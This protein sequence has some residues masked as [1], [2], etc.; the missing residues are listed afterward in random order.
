MY[1]SNRSEEI[2]QDLFR[3][4]SSLRDNDSTIEHEVRRILPK[5]HELRQETAKAFHLL[6]HLAKHQRSNRAHL[7]VSAFLEWRQVIA[8]IVGP[9]ST[10]DDWLDICRLHKYHAFQWSLQESTA[11]ALQTVTM[12]DETDLDSRLHGLA[13]TLEMNP[14]I[15]ENWIALVRGLGP[16]G[17]IVGVN[18]QRKCREAKCVACEKIVDGLNVD[19]SSLKDRKEAGCWWGNDRKDWWYENLLQLDTGTEH[20]VHFIDNFEGDCSALEAICIAL[21]DTLYCLESLGWERSSVSCSL[22]D[23]ERSVDWLEDLIHNPLSSMDDKQ[24]PDELRRQTVDRLLPRTF[25]ERIETP[26]HASTESLES[27]EL[28]GSDADSLEIQCAKALILCHLYSAAHPDIENFV[29]RL[30]AESW[31]DGELYTD[32][33][34]F[35]CLRW[36][37]LVGLDV[38]KIVG[39]VMTVLHE[40]P[41]AAVKCSRD[42][43]RIRGS[44]KLC[45]ECFYLAK[46]EHPNRNT[47][48]LRKLCSET[49]LGCPKCQVFLCARH[50]LSFEHKPEKYN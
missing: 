19:H 35:S 3:S 12:L 1:P 32:G 28:T 33:D 9:H 29:L 17:C 7:A 5:F 48:W 45:Q 20:V 21:E 25:A 39:D 16:I 36:L 15:K 41:V 8:L 13:R 37:Y 42:R 40:C 24:P 6:L 10:D 22:V 34:S 31:S 27:L 46:Q 14:G 43:T 26:Q 11:P 47:R 44:Q 38:V 18:E 4:R 49:N 30:V 2:G 23:H 50:W